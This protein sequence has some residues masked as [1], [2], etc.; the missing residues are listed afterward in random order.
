MRKLVLVAL[1]ALA[2]AVLVVLWSRSEPRPSTRI[3]AEVATPSG[4]ATAPA[5]NLATTASPARDV[6]VPL[7]VAANAPAATIATTKIDSRARVLGRCVFEDGAP[8]A[9]VVIAVHGW[10][11]NSERARRHGTPS[12]WTDPTTTSGADGRF[13]LRFDPPRAFQFT[14]DAKLAGFVEASWRWVELEPGSTT[15]LGDV[16]LARGGTITGRIVDRAGVV[17][18]GSWSVYAEAVASQG[19][20]PREPT[21]V[22]AKIDASG[23]FRLDHVAPGKS[24]L[25]AYSR[26]ANWIEGPTVEV[27]AGDVVEADVPYD[28]PDNSK[29]IVVLPFVRTFYA[30][31]FDVRGIALLLS[32]GSKREAVRIPGSS[33][34]YAF[35]DLAPGEYTVV[36]EDPRLEAWRQDGVRPGTSLD[37]KLRGAS[38]IALAVV[39]DATGAA[40]E[41]FTLDVR[42]DDSQSRPNAFRVRDVG[43]KAPADGVFNGLIPGDATLVVGAEGYAPQETKLVDLRAGEVRSITVRLQRGAVVRGRVL[44]HGTLAPA[45][46][47]VVSLRRELVARDSG[48]SSFDSNREQER[49]TTSAADGSFAFEALPDATWIVEAQANAFVRAARSVVVAPEAREPSIELVLPAT[50]TLSGTLRAPD[51]ASFEGLSVLVLPA[52][53]DERERSRLALVPSRANVTIPIARD[54]AF[55]SPALPLGKASVSLVLPESRQTTRAGWTSATQ[56]QR[57]L[58]DVEIVEGNVQRE[59]DLRA[60]FPGALKVVARI[61]GAPAANVNVHAYGSDPS[62]G[63]VAMS[64]DAQG[65]GT[66]AGLV[67]DSYQLKLVDPDFAW[68]IEDWRR[69]EVGP[70]AT[71]DV[72]LDLVRHEFDVAFVDDA[73]GEPLRETQLSIAFEAAFTSTAITTDARGRAKLSLRPGKH[74][75]RHRGAATDR[76]GTLVW[77]ESGPDPA[78]VRVPR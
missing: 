10:A 65:R 54:G 49:S 64:L 60:T 12:D 16:L 14:L 33:Q 66:L 61:N 4:P 73:T 18:T 11:G 52:A 51:G 27:R 3:V 26:I 63:M 25:K 67:P 31:A 74:F 59:F 71:L 70:G 5:E 68:T 57:A 46:A 20:G 37:A 58:G 34:S 53:L 40:V 2:I 28:G 9:E 44:A 69:F 48:R 62:Q 75:V 24:R 77:L 29:R 78:T 1:A 23:S 38:S 42:D 56:P 72:E 19:K 17:Q 13:E 55:V 15:D 21:R 36:I 45:A 41:P 47:V 22:R 8:A 50:G 7:V 39:D 35:D 6:A 32:D 76:V 43:G 30:V